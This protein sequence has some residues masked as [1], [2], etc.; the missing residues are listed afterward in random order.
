MIL[1]CYSVLPSPI[2]GHTMIQV[3]Y[4]LP[5]SI[6]RQIHSLHTPSSP[7]QKSTYNHTST[8]QIQ[9][10]KDKT[11]TMCHPTYALLS[12]GHKG[13]YL[14]FKQCAH[15]ADTRDLVARARVS[16]VSNLGLRLNINDRLCKEDRRERYEASEGECARCKR[17]RGAAGAGKGAEIVAGEEE[18]TVAGGGD[19][20]A[21]AAA[22]GVSVAVGEESAERAEENDGSVSFR[23]F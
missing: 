19:S 13:Q 17:A 7:L 10:L 8:P 23:D 2:T 22:E 14:A 1:D 6:K 20:S 3:P 16:R 5:F 15:S 18:S 21:A 11:V 4:D 9:P 12:C